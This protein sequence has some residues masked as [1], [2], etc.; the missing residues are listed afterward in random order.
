MSEVPTLVEFLAG[1]GNP[2]D[3][4]ALRFAADWTGDYF[5]GLIAL[6]TRAWQLRDDR[7][8]LALMEASC[9]S[10]ALEDAAD[11]YALTMWRWA[12]DVCRE[13]RLVILLQNFVLDEEL[14]DFHAR[15]M[16][17]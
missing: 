12:G 9:Y 17:P 8:E 3:V 2:R 14:D 11:P 1:D 5:D 16:T 7:E 6:A 13:P 15:M 10:C 4:L